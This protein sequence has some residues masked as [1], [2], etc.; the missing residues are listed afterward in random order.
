MLVTV[1]LEPSAGRLPAM[2]AVA[3]AAAN[4]LKVQVAA[5][6]DSQGNTA[7]YGE[8]PWLASLGH[9]DPRAFIAETEAAIVEAASAG[10]V[11]PIEHN[12]REWGVTAEAAADPAFRDVMS[13]ALR[14]EDFIEVS[15]P[16]G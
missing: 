16:G 5:R 1:D 12:L 8:W 4:L 11:E 3:R 13:S 14:E 9:D 7:D 2:E 10:S 15:R 6:A